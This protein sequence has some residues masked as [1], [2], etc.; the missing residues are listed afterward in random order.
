[1][2]AVRQAALIAKLR[3]W[4]L[5][6]WCTR[7]ARPLAR[8]PRTAAPPPSR[9]EDPYAALKTPAGQPIPACRRKGWVTDPESVGV[10]DSVTSCYGRVGNRFRLASVDQST[11]RRVASSWRRP[12]WWCSAPARATRFVSTRL[13]R[14]CATTVITTLARAC[15]G[16]PTYRALAQPARGWAAPW[17]IAS[18][19]GEPQTSG[20]SGRT[21][22][23]NALASRVTCAGVRPRISPSTST[24]WPDRCPARPVGRSGTGCRLASGGGR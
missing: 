8:Q 16:H 22:T 13:A 15:Q 24:A 21:I 2:V 3:R 12:P 23:R 17:I 18:E 1:M 11:R 5:G 20:K 7:P 14:S 10:E 19:L 9:A 4:I 6:R